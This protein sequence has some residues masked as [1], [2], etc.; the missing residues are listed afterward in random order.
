[1]SDVT[2]KQRNC[3]LHET[4]NNHVL[5]TMYCTYYE[6]LYQCSYLYYPEATN[7]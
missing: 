3:E 1:M 6:I 7:I 4:T 5:V 2:N